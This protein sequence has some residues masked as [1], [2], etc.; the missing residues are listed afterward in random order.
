MPGALTRW[1]PFAELGERKGRKDKR[2]LRRDRRYSS[3]PYVERRE[4]GS[5]MSAP[6]SFAHARFP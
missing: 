2:F 3:C 4:H 6:R 5:A 1:E